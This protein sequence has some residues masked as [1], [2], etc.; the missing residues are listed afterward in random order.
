[1]IQDQIT[2]IYIPVNDPKMAANKVLS[3][4]KQPILKAMGQKGLEYLKQE[5][6]PERYKSLILS[7]IEKTL[8]D[9]L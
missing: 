1:M 7:S 3:I 5:F 2:G 4:L 6:S 8:H 9:Q